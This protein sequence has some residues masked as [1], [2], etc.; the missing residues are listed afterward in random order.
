MATGEIEVKVS[1]V[2]VLNVSKTLP[3]PI[4][5]QDGPLANE[6][7]R[8]VHR[9]IVRQLRHHLSP[10]PTQFQAISTLHAPACRGLLG[11]HAYR[12]LIG[13]CNPMLCPYLGP[14]A[15]PPP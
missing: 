12:V 5:A 4:S 1:E 14:T 7:T 6:Q 2:T 11:A 9:Y 13:A 10:F 15:G 3:F 8:Q